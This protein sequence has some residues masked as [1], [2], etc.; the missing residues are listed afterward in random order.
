MS[1]T[2]TGFSGQVD[3]MKSS[4]DTVVAPWQAAET[5]FT[6]TLATI[7]E[8]EGASAQDWAQVSQ[9]LQ[10]IQSGW[11]SLMTTAADLN[12]S[13]SQV[14]TNVSLSLTMTDAEI[15][16]TLAGATNVPMSHYLV[17]A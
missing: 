3:A 12:L 14:A 2:L 1:T 16:Q 6:T 7:G 10:E 9:E 17:A 5:Y 8:I 13:K 4:L 15:T 11:N